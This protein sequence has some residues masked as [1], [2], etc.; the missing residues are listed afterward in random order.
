MALFWPVAHWLPAALVLSLVVRAGRQAER[1]R[2]DMSFIQDQTEDQR[3]VSYVGGL[4]TGG[5]EQKEMRMF[6]LH[7]HL[8]GRWRGLRRGVRA[9]LLGQKRRNALFA[10]PA[11]VLSFA[12]AAGTAVLL[13]LALARHAITLG[14][15][16]ALFGGVQ[17]VENAGAQ[18]AFQFAQGNASVLQVGYLREFLDLPDEPAPS[19]AMPFPTPLRKGIR[20]EGLT[21]TYPGRNEPVLHDLHLQLRPGERVALVGENGSGKSTLAKC[22]LGLYRPDAGRISVDGV[23]YRDI[24]S[25]S[26]RAAVSAA[27]QDYVNFQFTLRESIGVGD[28]AAVDQDDRVLAAAHR[29][30]ADEVA[31][32]LARGYDNPVGG[33]LEGSSGLSGGQWQRVAISRAFMRD[34]QLLILDEP[35]AAL[36]PQAEAALHARF[37]ETLAG[38]TALLVSHRQGSARLADRILVLRDGRI[39][40]DGTHDALLAVGGEYARMWEAQAQWYR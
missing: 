11:D 40:E 15:F 24:A 18:F 30:G 19:A 10:L 23:D 33:V 3:R 38:R 31:A 13:V 17:M 34:A 14:A 5:S 35:A 37:A 7:Q 12:V 26:L 27:Y 32:S 8:A 9:A 20:C 36:D 2:R 39:A 16:V 6:N 21:F 25:D 1:S 4:L 28:V 29:G 22:L